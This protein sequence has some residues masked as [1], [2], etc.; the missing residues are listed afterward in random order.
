MRIGL[1]DKIF[2]PE[3][4]ELP[5]QFKELGF[6]KNFESFTHV[7]LDGCD[8]TFNLNGL[9]PNDTKALLL[10]VI[11]TIDHQARASAERELK[12]KIHNLLKV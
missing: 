4:G 11:S 12:M 6:S 3:Y 1:N 5:E 8:Y 10:R 9:D 2:L 7:S